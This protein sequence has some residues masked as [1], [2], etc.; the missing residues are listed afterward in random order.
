V[1]SVLK[2]RIMDAFAPHFR[3]LSARRKK[4]RRTAF[5]NC[6]DSRIKNLSV[7]LKF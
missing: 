3:V 2:V 6:S 1:V 7:L 5:S 4:N